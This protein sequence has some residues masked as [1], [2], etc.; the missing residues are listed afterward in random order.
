MRF[1]SSVL[2]VYRTLVVW[3]EGLSMLKN[4]QDF[5]MNHIPPLL[6]RKGATTRNELFSHIEFN[7]PQISFSLAM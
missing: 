6:F 1:F 3:K 5:S 2:E 7:D 4:V